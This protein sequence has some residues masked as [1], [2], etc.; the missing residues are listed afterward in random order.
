MVL[1]DRLLG[2]QSPIAFCALF[3]KA[4]V[5]NCISIRSRCTNEPPIKTLRATHD[6]IFANWNSQGEI[7][8]CCN[9]HLWNIIFPRKAF[10]AA[11]SKC[12][13]AG[14]ERTGLSMNA[15]LPAGLYPGD[16]VSAPCQSSLLLVSQ[17]SIGTTPERRQP[18]QTNN[19]L[20]WAI[21]RK[22]KTLYQ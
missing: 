10:S 22:G 13:L 9:W 7:H 16:R 2:K 17:E 4:S 18:V 5:N 21:S 20:S 1:Q 3:S 14:P 15:S 19:Y 11:A 6:I 12:S 8:M